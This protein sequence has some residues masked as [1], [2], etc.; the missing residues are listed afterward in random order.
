MNCGD[1]TTDGR[2]QNNRSAQA[3]MPGANGVAVSYLQDLL[4]GHGQSSI[5]DTVYGG[6]GLATSQAM[7][8]DRTK[9]GF[10]AGHEVDSVTLADVVTRRAETAVLGRA[11]VPLVLYVPFTPIARFVWLTSLFDAGFESGGVF[12][13]L[14]L[15]TDHCGC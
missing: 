8:S 7:P 11:Y 3:P 1:A 2:L 15:N 13:M 6:Y 9:Y 4:R 10:P 12:A 5:P 14:N